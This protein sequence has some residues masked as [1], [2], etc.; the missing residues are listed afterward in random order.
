VFTTGRGSVVGSALA[1]VVKVSAN[2]DTYRNMPHD[3]DVNAGR[4][5]EGRATLNEVGREIF[6][7]VFQVAG[8]TQ[9]ASERLGHREFILTYKSFDPIRPECLP[10]A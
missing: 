7:L 1:P 6:D 8:G 10:R 4:I 5:L 9:T 2:P 3:M